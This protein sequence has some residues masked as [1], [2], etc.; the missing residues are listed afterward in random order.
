[1]TD[2][3]ELDALVEWAACYECGSGRDPAFQ[4]MLRD[5][6]QA[7]ADKRDLSLRL[8]R[9]M[10][11]CGA[12]QIALR[13]KNMTRSSMPLTTASRQEMC[14]VCLPYKHRRPTV[15][16]DHEFD[17][18]YCS[19]CV[20][21]YAD[22][23]VREAVGVA[24]GFEM[25]LR[26]KAVRKERE[27]WERWVLTAV[28]RG[29]KDCYQMVEARAISIEAER[30]RG[31]QGECPSV[32]CVICGKTVYTCENYGEEA[33]CKKHPEGSELSATDGW[34]CSSECFDK[35][36]DKLLYGEPKAKHE[37]W[38]PAHPL[39]AECACHETSARNCPVDEH[40]GEGG[41]K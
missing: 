24:V 14:P 13:Q 25:G 32:P 40:R 1:M 16:E 17:N 30:A 18:R 21:V 36:A 10:R 41:D 23:R 26:D 29:V 39:I 34:V 19:K 33:D 38:C 6:I 2:H 3:D 9:G 12:R 31:Q 15:C 37:P 28:N 22:K 7:Y 35:V 27:V 5:R 8:L 11:R 20:D 4:Q